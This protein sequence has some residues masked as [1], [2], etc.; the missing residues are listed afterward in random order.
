[1]SNSTGTPLGMRRRD[2]LRLADGAAAGMRVAMKALLRHAANVTDAVEEGRLHVD[3]L[4][5]LLGSTNQMFRAAQCLEMI[6]ADAA[7]RRKLAS[8]R[9]SEPRRRSQGEAK[10][11]AATSSMIRARTRRSR[12]GIQNPRR[13]R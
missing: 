4:F 5:Y 10:T 9:K 6:A 8:R 3:Q 2:V 1:M 11:G 13:R 12:S 7:P